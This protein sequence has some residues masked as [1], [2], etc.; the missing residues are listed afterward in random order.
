MKISAQAPTQASVDELFLDYMNKYENVFMEQIGEQVFIF[1]ALGRKDWRDIVETEAIDNC[2]KEEVICETCTLYPQNFDFS[3]CEEAGI[4]TVLSKKIIERSMLDSADSLHNLLTHFRKKTSEDANRQISCT[5][6]EAFPEYDIE[7]I[8][9]WDIIK[10]ADFMSRAEFILHALRGVPID[11]RAMEEASAIADSEQEAVPQHPRT[12]EI[13]SNVKQK[14]PPTAPSKPKMSREKL[15]ELKRI[16]PGIDWEADLGLNGP[17]SLLNQDVDTR[18]RSSIPLDGSEDGQN[19]LP[20][21][22][23][24]RFKVIEKK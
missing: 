23:R 3:N 8:E 13:T 2:Q 5:I 16:A 20:E 10:T 19:A 12:E 14:N 11:P 15:E 18:R 22:M 17:Q 4:P 9:N 21:A 24:D 7:D 1:K 6:H